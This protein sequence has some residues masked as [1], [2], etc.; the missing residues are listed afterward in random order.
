MHRNLGMSVLEGARRGMLIVHGGV[1]KDVDNKAD[2][3]EGIDKAA[4]LGS[5]SLSEDKRV[6]IGKRGTAVGTGIMDLGGMNKG[7]GTDSVRTS[8]HGAATNEGTT[9][10][11]TARQARKEGTRISTHIEVQE[12]YRY[13]RS[14]AM[15]AQVLLGE[16]EMCAW[17]RG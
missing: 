4:F 8:L 13:T 7:S 11:L 2:D 14:Q 6:H 10:S 12:Q 15:T 3:N 16:R 1:D 9:R 5:D 17:A